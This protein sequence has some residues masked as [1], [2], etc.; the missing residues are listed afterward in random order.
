MPTTPSS[1]REE[2]IDSVY[3]KRSFVGFESRYPDVDK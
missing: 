1:R 3:A 2:I